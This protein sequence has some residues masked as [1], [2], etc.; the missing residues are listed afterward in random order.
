MNRKVSFSRD[1]KINKI[2]KFVK[3]HD[4]LT[5]YCAFIKFDISI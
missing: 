1:K 5:Y 3:D 2:V 4:I